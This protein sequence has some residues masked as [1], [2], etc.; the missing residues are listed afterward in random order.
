[1]QILIIAFLFEIEI[2][3][4]GIPLLNNKHTVEQ[5]TNPQFI[6]DPHPGWGR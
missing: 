3:Q 6:K 4:S 2:R 5:K 1:M